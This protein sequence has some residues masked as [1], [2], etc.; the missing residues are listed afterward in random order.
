MSLLSTLVGE[1]EN[2]HNSVYW[3]YITMKNFPSISIV[4][5]TIL[6]YMLHF[7]MIV[8]EL[9]E[10]LLTVLT[11]LMKPVTVQSVP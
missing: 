5:I 9:K 3:T 10:V 2:K 4:I 8:T 11:E 7:P 6:K 1:V